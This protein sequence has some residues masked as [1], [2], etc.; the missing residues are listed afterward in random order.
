MRGERGGST[1]GIFFTHQ[2]LLSHVSTIPRATKQLI[3]HCFFTVESTAW[4]IRGPP[5][6][7]MIMM[8]TILK[9]W[10]K[11]V[12]SGQSKAHQIFIEW[13]WHFYLSMQEEK[14]GWQEEF[15]FKALHA[16]ILING[17]RDTLGFKGPLYVASLSTIH[18]FV[19]HLFLE[20]ST[21]LLDQSNNATK[22]HRH[23]LALKYLS[24]SFIGL[25]KMCPTA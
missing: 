18:F 10:D 2:T 3:L 9:H 20:R 14:K 23:N 12:F 4:T 17:L 24:K 1:K 16:P 15:F 22:Y 5:S 11:S 25:M 19:F 7:C 6:R 21:V 8:I 13:Q